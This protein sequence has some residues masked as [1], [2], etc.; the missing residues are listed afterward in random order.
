MD[1]SSPTEMVPIRISRRLLGGAAAGVVLAAAATA[2]FVA[3]PAA[4]APWSL[5]PTDPRV[6]LDDVEKEVIRRYP[7][8]DVSA[9][10]LTGMLGRGTVT[11][12]DVRTQEEFAAGHLPGAVRIE[13]GSSSADILA[14]HRDRLSAGP[15]V[16]YCAVGVRSS[17]VMMATLREIAPHASGGVYNLRGGVFRWSAE[18]RALVKGA[19]PG[20][21]HPF[22]DNW[23][24][25]LAR[26]QSR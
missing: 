19:E 16:F 9:S 25:L 21:V 2:V 18:G 1:A 5:D 10:T 3:A 22:D 11:L 23:G 4:L 8:P 7:V 15:V 17:R 24:R 26:T 6:S 12:F 14:Q 20:V 13:P